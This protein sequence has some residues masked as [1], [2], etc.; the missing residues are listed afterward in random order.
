MRGASV[1]L[2]K[3]ATQLSR[4]LSDLGAL[5]DAATRAGWHIV[6]SEG[7]VDTTT[8]QGRMLPMFLGIVVELERTFTGSGRRQ[9]DSLPRPVVSRWAR[10]HPCLPLCGSGSFKPATTG[11]LAGGL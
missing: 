5:L 1:L 3:G 6:T 9:P 7:L 11:P 10:R 8:N 4:N 2:A